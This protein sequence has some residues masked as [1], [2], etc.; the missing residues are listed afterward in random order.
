M[1]SRLPDLHELDFPTKM[2]DYCLI[3]FRFPPLD[4]DVVLSARCY[5]PERNVL[6]RDLMNLRIP[7]S[8]QLREVNIAAERNRLNREPK[9][10]VQKIDVAMKTMIRSLIG[11]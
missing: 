2:I 9:P 3:P 10:F 5:D 4:G 7:P 11:P 1:V 8:F 6:S